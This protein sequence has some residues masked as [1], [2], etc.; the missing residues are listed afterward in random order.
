MFNE[1]FN[2]AVERL[3]GGDESLAAARALEEV[4]REDYADDERFAD[5]IQALERYA[6]D[7][8]AGTAG[9][10]VLRTAVREVL[11]DETTEFEPDR[12]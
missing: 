4:V 2:Q 9:P 12:G 11:G 6:P 3:L 8:T 1:R 7:D 10:A 5:L